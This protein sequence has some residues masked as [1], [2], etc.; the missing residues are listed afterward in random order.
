MFNRIVHHIDRSA[1][2]VNDRLVLALLVVALL[3]VAAYF[4]I[5]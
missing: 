4:I 2:R 1:S 5:H 3:S